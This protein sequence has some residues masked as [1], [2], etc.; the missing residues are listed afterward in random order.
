MRFLKTY[1]LVEIY[2]FSNDTEGKMG[3]NVT[4]NS[5]EKNQQAAESSSLSAEL[6]ARIDQLEKMLIHTRKKRIGQSIVIWSCTAVII[7]ICAWFL[8]TFNSLIRNYD[9]KL[10]IRELQKSSGIIIESPEFQSMLMDTRKI[11][12]PAYRQAMKDEINSN[13]PELR[14]KAEA[15]L[16]SLKALAVKKIKQNFVAQ[17]NKDFKKIEKDLLKRYP[18]LNS[19]KLNE[20]YEKASVLFAEKLTVSLNDFVNQAI[21]K[22]AGLDET[23]RQ[24]KKGDAYKALNKKSV[25]E[26]ENLL[27]ESMLE[28]WIY[29][30]NPEK[31]AKLAEA[32][33]EKSAKRK[34]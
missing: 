32:E 18:D 34:K 3:K 27:V 21:N 20:A 23:F 28:L 22:L 13:A 1:C 31:G 4:K 8:M 24:F 7:A 6:S 12:L 30:L 26:V 5:P 10:L 9:K 2:Y 16:T 33:I 19:E 14:A 15:E 25:Q 17:I 29:E 11:F